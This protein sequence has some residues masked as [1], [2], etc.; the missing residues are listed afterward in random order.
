MLVSTVLVALISLQP[1]L[2]QSAEPPPFAD[3]VVD[4]RVLFR[5]GS[6]AEF[7]AQSRASSVNRD[8]QS[9]LETVPLNQPI[10]VSIAER[11]RLST[12]RV[13]NRHLLTVTDSDFRMG[14]TRQEQAE[15]WVALLETALVKAQRER[16]PGYA[17]TVVW[18]ILGAL[19]LALGLY[20]AL[21]RL[22]KKL[23]RRDASR[24]RRFA[25]NKRW[26]KPVLI[27]LQGTIVFL[28]L[29]YVGE[30]LPIARTARYNT[31]QFLGN[32]FNSNLLTAGM[33]SYS[34]LDVSRLAVLAV[35]LWVGVRGLVAI[36]K[37]RFLQAAIP[38]RGVQ[39][40]IATLLQFA[41]MG[42]GLFILLQAWGID[43]SA[44]ALLAS[45]LGVGLGFGL[46]DIVNNF[47]SGWIL[48]IERPVQ[49]GDLVDVGSVLGRVERVGMRSTHLHTADGVSIILPNN[50]LVQNKVVNWSHGQPV[51][52]IHMH[53][54][55]AYGS[56]V[57]TVHKAVMEV[58]LA[59]PKVLRYPRP[60]L[61][62]LGFGESSLDFNLLLW[63][64]DPAEQFDVQSDVYYLLEANFRRHHIEIPFPQRDVKVQLSDEA[65]QRFSGG[66]AVPTSHLQTP[67]N[68]QSNADF[69]L[70]SQ[71]PETDLDRLS[72]IDR[73]SESKPVV[74]T[75]IPAD[76]LTEVTRYSAI[77]QGHKSVVKTE[78]DRLVEQMLGM[79]GLDIRDRR[80]RLT[81]YA[82][83]FVGSEAVDWIVRT[84]KATRQEAVRLGQRLVARDVIHHVTYEHAFKDEYLFYKFYQDE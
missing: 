25:R 20:T 65:T 63:S 75:G 51:S 4:G 41:L 11:D 14:M 26:F 76:I 5:L 21:Y 53:F 24:L 40:A 45:V 83:C 8:L 37:V 80:F 2:A 30:L 31:L 49:V 10:R 71:L 73:R 43:L 81:L 22:R 59:H 72:D 44:L 68:V 27:C 77:L 48:L 15:D 55:V 67:A 42:L 35:L 74:K 60:Q 46:Q 70:S 38:D 52:R 58:A 17:Q 9:A 29:A 47:I 57:K 84:Q 16:S 39:D 3:V 82:N 62:F 34:L 6:I 13:N 66:V 64:N 50:E 69:S 61:R 36:V 23:L 54:G 1:G 7:T 32:A 56:E 28:F 19:A 18:R 33:Q 78:I 79:D 12:I